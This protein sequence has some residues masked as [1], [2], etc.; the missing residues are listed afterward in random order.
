[1][2]NSTY[3][4]ATLTNLGPLVTQF[5][6][7]PSCSEPSNLAVATQAS[8]GLR[9]FGFPECNLTASAAGC[10]PDGSKIDELWNP[11]VT[12]FINTLVYHSPGI[13]CLSGWTTAGS[14]VGPSGWDSAAG[15]FTRRHFPYRGNGSNTLPDEL[16][17]FDQYVGALDPSETLVHC[18]PR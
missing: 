16:R 14:I 18:C 3:F 10:F 9:L 7:A 11:T 12:D 13:A 15:F 4:G 17:A 8:D 1:M 2:P 5:T 6:P